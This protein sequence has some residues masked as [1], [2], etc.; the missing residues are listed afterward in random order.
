MTGIRGLCLSRRK[1]QIS[2]LK[3]KV[4]FGWTFFFLENLFCY[5][6]LH[7][8][9]PFWKDKPAHP[10]PS[11]TVEQRRHL[12][13]VFCDP[14]YR[15]AA[16]RTRVGPRGI[17][18]CRR[19]LVKYIFGINYITKTDFTAGSCVVCF[20]FFS[21]VPHGIKDRFQAPAKFCQ[22]VFYLRRNFRIDFAVYKTIAFHI[23]KL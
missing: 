16:A 2:Q 10:Y 8:E 3:K 12:D 9:T 6:L 21:P 19:T 15:C 11:R 18:M 22:R 20:E 4:P 14:M 5:I 13:R 17:W 23:T 1:E 7:T